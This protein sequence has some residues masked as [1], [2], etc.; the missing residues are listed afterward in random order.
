MTGKEEGKMKGTRTLLCS[1]FMSAALLSVG[2]LS[3]CNN[4]PAPVP[5]PKAPVSE[6]EVAPDVEHRISYSGETLAVIAAWYTGRATNWQA[7]RDANPGLRPER[8]NLGQIIMIP[9]DLVVQHDPMPKRFVTDNA[10]KV[11]SKVTTELKPTD[12]VPADVGT[13]PYEEGAVPGTTTGMEKVPAEIVKDAPDPLPVEPSMGSEVPE[14]VKEAPKVKDVPAVGSQPANGGGQP[15]KDAPPAM[16]SEREK[17]LD[18]LL[19]Q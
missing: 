2:M 7:I 13:D 14:V 3:G 10:A 18:E 8:L 6:P 16:D 15:T 5:P 19:A 12:G 1:S 17:L 9:G 11:R 4:R